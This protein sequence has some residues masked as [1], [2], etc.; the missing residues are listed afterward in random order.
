LAVSS[1]AAAASATVV[2]EIKVT[3]A[4][5]AALPRASV[6]LPGRT[7]ECVTD[8]SGACRLEG[9]PAGVHDVS[10]RRAGFLGARKEVRLA[11]G[12]SARVEFALTAPVHFSESVTVSPT[13]HDAF[14]SVL[15]PATSHSR[16]GIRT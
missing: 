3:D 14:E 13:G 7:D 10:V 16:S 12:A 15:I 8:A 2:L 6:T 9:L 11:H 1:P 5:G 4:D